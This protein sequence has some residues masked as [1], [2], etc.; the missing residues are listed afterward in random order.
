MGEGVEFSHIDKGCVGVELQSD[1]V[2]LA[3]G[4]IEVDDREG[5]RTAVHQLNE[6]R[7]EDMD[8]GECLWSEAI[9]R[10]IGRL[11][12]SGVGVGPGFQ[13]VLRVGK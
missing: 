9:R 2:C 12:F 3:A 13:S 1:G 6:L 5:V 10:G 8:A 7:R 4:E 11:H